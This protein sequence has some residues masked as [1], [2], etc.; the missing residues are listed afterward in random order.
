[1]AFTS[2]GNK[3]QS[4]DGTAED[5]QPAVPETLSS[6]AEGTSL[7]GAR[8][9]PTGNIFRRLLWTLALAS[10]FGFCIYQL[11]QTVE[12]FY[13][14]P[15]HTKMTTKTGNKTVNIAFPAVT[16]C[17]F[18]FFNRRRYRNL[19]KTNSNAS[20]EE[21]ERKFIVFEKFM[22]RSED[23]LD[24]DSK[25]R[26]PELFLREVSTNDHYLKMFSHLIEDMLLPSSIFDS[27]FINGKACGSE[28]FTSFLSSTFGMCYTFNSGND[29]R[30]VINATMSG[31]VNGLKLLLNVER[32]SYVD[33]PIKPFAG[34]TVRIHDQHTYPFVEQFGFSVQPGLRTLCSI[35]QK[36][37]SL[38][39]TFALC[40]SR[41]SSFKNKMSR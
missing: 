37:V 38:Q 14:R 15:F 30:P 41:L 6:F 11:Y 21:I 20:N 24:N 23:V 2:Q 22:A 16:L 25:R 5:R 19:M 12:A 3:V 18:N 10:C 13:D 17:N 8:F 29:G 32:D 4:F 36:K 9:L 39:T 40:F 1:M 34:L 26:N 33:N 28:N 31:D 7:H 35:K 27:C